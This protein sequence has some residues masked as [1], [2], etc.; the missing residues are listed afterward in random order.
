M[1]FMTK[2][3]FIIEVRL[4]DVMYGDYGHKKTLLYRKGR[5]V[6]CERKRQECNLF[7][8]F[9]YNIFEFA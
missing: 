2:K 6:L 8:R 7:L 5:E 1:M 9:F 3:S 4:H